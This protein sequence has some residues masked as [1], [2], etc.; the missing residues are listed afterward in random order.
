M[1]KSLKGGIKNLN[2]LELIRF[3]TPR[4]Y[5]DRHI[6]EILKVSDKKAKKT[7][8]GGRFSSGFILAGSGQYGFTN[9]ILDIVGIGLA[10]FGNFL[11]VF[12][13]RF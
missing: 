1:R 13:G 9:Q 2:G 12:Q 4:D 7:A 8:L 3:S 5:T 6:P 11:S 10:Q